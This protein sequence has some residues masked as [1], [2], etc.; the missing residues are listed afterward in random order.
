MKDWMGRCHR[1]FEE[2]GSFTMSRFNTQLICPEC[3]EKEK[4]HASY[5][6]AADAEMAAVRRGDYNFPGIGKP[7]DL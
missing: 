2:S 5:K 3:E 6:R 4:K 1:C 7:V